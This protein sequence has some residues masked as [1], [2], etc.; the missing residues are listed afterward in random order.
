MLLEQCMREMPFMKRSHKTC[1]YVLLVIIAGLLVVL[2]DITADDEALKERNRN[3]LIEWDLPTTSSSA[4]YYSECLRLFADTVYDRTDGQVI[5]HIHYGGALGYAGTEMISVVRDGLVPLADM[6]KH[7]QSGEESFLS[8]TALP[9]LASDFIQ[10]RML[11]LFAQP[12]ENQ[13]LEAQ[14]QNVLFQVPRPGQIVYT[15]EPVQSIKDLKGLRMRVVS[16]GDS[17]LFSLLGAT[18]VQMQEGE[19]IT[20]L[21][22]GLIDGV[23]ASSSV[24]ADGKYWEIT[25]YAGRWNWHSSGNVVTVNKDAWDALPDNLK[26]VIEKTAREL[27]PVFTRRAIQVNREAEELLRLNGMTV[28][29]PE[30][31]LMDE[32]LNA[33]LT[34]WEEAKQKDPRVRKVIADYL[35]VIDRSHAGNT[36]VPAVHGNH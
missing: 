32:I 6:V 33:S 21:A 29:D 14:N 3:V 13:L 16:R 5:I 15:Q 8:M 7:A 17:Q 11:Q 12:V 2:L 19:V 9:F 18:P 28:Y 10:L 20:S 35:S 23:V 30:G 26:Q 31:E 1:A 22:T 27:E 24:G 36:V 4:N 25:R 34:M